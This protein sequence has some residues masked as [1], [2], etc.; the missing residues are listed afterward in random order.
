MPRYQGNKRQRMFRVNEISMVATLQNKKRFP[1]A[2]GGGGGYEMSEGQ[3]G[4]GYYGII[5]TYQAGFL[6]ANNMEQYGMGVSPMRS[7]LYQSYG[8]LTAFSYKDNYPYPQE[9]QSTTLT[10]TARTKKPTKTQTTSK[11]IAQCIQEK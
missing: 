4:K 8:W 2:V 6:E 11:S 10:S 7:D 1:F 3:K 9:Q 5:K